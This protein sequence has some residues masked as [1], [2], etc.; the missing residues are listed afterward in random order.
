[1]LNGAIDALDAISDP[2]D[3]IT[4]AFSA[5]MED[6]AFKLLPR[7][8]DRYSRQ[9]DKALQIILDSRARSTTLP[10]PC[11]TEIRPTTKNEA[12]NPLDA[13]L[14][15]ESAA[16][17]SEDRPSPETKNEASIPLNE[18]LIIPEAAAAPTE[19]RPGH[20][21]TPT[22]STASSSGW[23]TCRRR[24]GPSGMATHVHRRAFP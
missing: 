16:P 21:Q 14:I 13:S 8:E 23:P 10:V 9:Y 20:T 7:V 4:Q 2:L 17:K 18:T 12:P 3:R 19:D 6:P 11:A 24:H 1:M 15:T 5:L 22:P